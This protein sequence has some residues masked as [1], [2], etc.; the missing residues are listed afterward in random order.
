MTGNEFLGKIVLEFSTKGKFINLRQNK[1]L[2]VYIVEF[3]KVYYDNELFVILG[4]MM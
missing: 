1:Y 4:G 2:Q 3:F